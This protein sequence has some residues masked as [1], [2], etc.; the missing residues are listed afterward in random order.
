MCVSV[1]NIK[2]KHLNLHAPFD[3]CL[4]KV[5][6]LKMTNPTN[7]ASTHKPQHPSHAWQKRRHSVSQQDLHHKSEPLAF[8]TRKLKAK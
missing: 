6:Y 2:S 5:D 7:L 3:G 1:H 4:N 8:P